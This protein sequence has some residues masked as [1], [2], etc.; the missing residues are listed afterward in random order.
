MRWLSDEEEEDELLPS[1][2]PAGHWEIRQAVNKGFKEKG[3]CLL[4]IIE[5][6]NSHLC[7]LPC[8]YQVAREKG[9]LYGIH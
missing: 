3:K 2:M 6:K 9:V 1:W 8:H 5:M 4:D 7:M